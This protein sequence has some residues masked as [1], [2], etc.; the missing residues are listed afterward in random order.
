MKSENPSSV[1]SPADSYSKPTR[2]SFPKD[3]IRHEWLPMLLDT[4]FITDQGVYEGIARE[5]RKGRVLACCKGCSA[6]CRAHTTIPIYP[7]E[8]TGLYWYVIE[9]TSGDTRE[10]LK[11]QCASHQAGNPCPLLVDGA[12]GVHP[13]RPQA[14]RH[15]NVFSRPCAE[16]EDAFYTR[17]EDVLT[18]LKKYKDEALA[19]ML[20][21]HNVIGRNQRREAIKTG[22]LHSYA[23]VLQELD[24]S[25]LAKRMA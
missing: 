9:Q 10:K 12:C 23:Q 3:E 19:K 22:L 13:L 2:L 7:L 18:P 6:C 15:F 14:C 24:W 20:P 8:I 11:Q 1:L 21:F 17:R 5:Q 4:Y 25:K 16:G